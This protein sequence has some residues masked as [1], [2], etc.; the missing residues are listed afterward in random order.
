M[1]DILIIIIIGLMLLAPIG[2]RWM[3]TIASA[4][5]FKQKLQYHK[6]VLDRIEEKGEPRNGTSH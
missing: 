6:Q 2:I 5:Y 4:A 1:N 3:V